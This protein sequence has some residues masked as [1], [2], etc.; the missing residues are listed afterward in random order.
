MM[1]Q[2]GLV[3]PSVAPGENMEL[4]LAAEGERWVEAAGT[5][6]HHVT[7][8]PKHLHHHHYHHHH[9]YYCYRKHGV[10]HLVKSRHPPGVST[11]PDGDVHFMSSPR[12]L[13]RLMN[14]ILYHKI[15]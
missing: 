11:A 10:G 6:L 8:H 1:M 7:S 12:A 2:K 5:R 3:V 14:L 9:H 4:K 13:G 15:W